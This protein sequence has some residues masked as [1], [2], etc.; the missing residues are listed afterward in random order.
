[1]TWDVSR[2]ETRVFTVLELQINLKKPSKFAKVNGLTVLKVRLFDG[3]FAQSTNK[4]GL[5]RNEGREVIKSLQWQ[6]D[7]KKLKKAINSVC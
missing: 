1:M 6:V 4:A 2:R 7:F 3:S 5:T